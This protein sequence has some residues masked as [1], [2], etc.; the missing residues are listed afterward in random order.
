MAIYVIEQSLVVKEKI[1]ALIAKIILT[2]DLTLIENIFRPKQFLEFLLDEIKLKKL[3]GTIKGGI[4]YLIG[5][6]IGKFS[7]MLNDYKIEIHDVIFYEFKSLVNNAKKFECKAITG[8]LKGYLFL[9]EDP[10]LTF[11][12][13][14]ELYVFLKSL[15]KPLEDANSIKI[16]KLALQ[17]ISSHGKVFHKQLQ[18]DSINLFDDIFDLCNHKNYE[19][20][21]AANEGIEKISIHIA[22]SLTEDNDLH[23]DAFKYLLVKI[24]TVLDTKTTSILINTAISLSKILCNH[25]FKKL[26]YLPGPLLDLWEKIF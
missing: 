6:L 15:M 11:S 8:I 2:F 10:H 17:V 3:N 26:E 4:W 1:L 23:K 24:K 16:N 14:N 18:K 5:I 7:L 12:Q 19:L 13:I 20:K 22:D 21:M 25:K 9:L